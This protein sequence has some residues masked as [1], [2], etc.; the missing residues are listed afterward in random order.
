MIASNESPGKLAMV[1]MNA[2]IMADIEWAFK[3]Y[4]LDSPVQTKQRWLRIK[5]AMEQARD[6]LN[7]YIDLDLAQSWKAGDYKVAAEEANRDCNKEAVMQCAGKY[8]AVY[9]RAMGRI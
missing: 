5:K 9:E 8:L 3:D 2:H 4:P 1:T 7:L 6:A